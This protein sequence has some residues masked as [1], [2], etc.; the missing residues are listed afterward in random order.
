MLGIKVNALIF[1]LFASEAFTSNK[2]IDSELISASVQMFCSTRIADDLAPL[3][4]LREGM[5]LE[6]MSENV[7]RETQSQL[8]EMQKK[9]KVKYRKN[10]SK[11]SLS[12][13][14]RASLSD[15]IPLASAGAWQEIQRKCP[16]AAKSPRS[17]AY[18]VEFLSLFL[19]T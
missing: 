12:D 10:L 18:V 6:K 14:V 4:E 7:Y 15:F 1:F 2:G 11:I 8:S 19:P 16:K 13:R 5:A 9:I 3:V 17:S